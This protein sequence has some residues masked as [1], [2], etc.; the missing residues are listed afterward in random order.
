MNSL[1]PSSVMKSRLCYYCLI[2]S[3][4]GVM[5]ALTSTTWAA[6]EFKRTATPIK[7]REPNWHVSV[8][9]LES[10]FY[11]PARQVETSLDDIY[12]LSPFTGL[13]SAGAL[14]VEYNFYPGWHI[15]AGAI[16]R[17]VTTSGNAAE[18]PTGVVETFK[19]SQTFLGGELG[20]RYDMQ[21]FKRWSLIGLVE[22]DMGQSISLTVTAG[23][24]V[25][26]PPLGMPTYFILTG[27]F[28]YALPLNENY[29]F[30]MGLKGGAVMTTN[31]FSALV[32]LT[33]GLRRAF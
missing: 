28:S 14:R 8:S 7:K 4:W 18:Q 32:D 29:F 11:Q 15:L 13:N 21:S 6:A 10:Y 31:P 17:Q 19:L 2:I 9:Y 24:P 12:N 22:Y 26:E 16:Y 27:G 33:L 1:M 30:D 5:S 3:F 20:L 23:P 25:A